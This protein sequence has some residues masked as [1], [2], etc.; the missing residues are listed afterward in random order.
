MKKVMITAA[1]SGAE[2]TTEQ[3]PALPVTPQEMAL[4]AKACR[5]A[6]ASIVH[7]HVRDDA[8]NPTASVERFNECLVAIRTVTDIVVEFT[9][10]G[11]STE[12]RPPTPMPVHSSSTSVGSADFIMSKASTVAGIAPGTP[13]TNVKW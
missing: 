2:T 13:S 9:T 8:G 10:G 4:A 6:G 1:I 5:D 11:M 12:P 3:Q 7:L